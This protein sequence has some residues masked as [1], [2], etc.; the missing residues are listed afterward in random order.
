MEIA[1]VGVGAVAQ[2]NY[3]PTL[4]RHKD[5]SL[6][7]CSRSIERVEA[8]GQKFGVRVARTLDVLSS[9]ISGMEKLFFFRLKRWGSGR[10]WFST[11]GSSIRYNAPSA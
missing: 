4:L 9:K 10:P 7:C 6:T 11:T 3:L 8:I 2:D 1:I 5:V